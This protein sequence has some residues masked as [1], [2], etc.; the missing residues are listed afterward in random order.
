MAKK[1]LFPIGAIFITPGALQVCASFPM[2]I[3]VLLIRHVSGDWSDMS[4]D[5]EEGNRQAIRVLCGH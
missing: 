1:Q 2:P 4:P 5:S 3:D